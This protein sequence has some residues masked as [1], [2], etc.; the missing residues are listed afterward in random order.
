MD[1]CKKTLF[2]S[3]A[4]L[5]SVICGC[6]DS[7]KEIPPIEPKAVLIHPVV[8][9]S[10]S[11][12][13]NK[14]KEKEGLEEE[15]SLKI[16]VIGP[17]TGEE[18]VWGLSVVEGVL[19]A[20]GRFNRQGGVDGREIEVLHY[21]TGGSNGAHLTE[22]AV[23]DLVRQKA[24]A[25]ISAPTGWSTFA[26]TRIVNET[27]TIFISV[28]TRRRIG[29][30]GPY[31]FRS[32][33]ADELATDNLIKYAT[34]V[35]NYTDF[36][37]VTSSQ[38]DYS[39]D[40]SALFKR[41]IF[42]HR[43]TLS[44]DADTYDTYTGKQNLGG[45]MDALKAQADTLHAVIFTG[46]DSGGVLFAQ[47]MR[48]VGLDQPILGGEDLFTKGYLAGGEAVVGSLLYATFSPHRKS[49]KVA[50]FKQ[51][52]GKDNPD[53]FAALAY[54]TF[55]LIAQAIQTAG[56]TRTSKVRDAIVDTKDFEGATGKMSFTPKGTPVKDSFIYRVAKDRDGE[57]FVLL[58]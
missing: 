34:E 15:R 37:M 57:K 25:I 8:T 33:L 22:R 16:G 50:E 3:A 56:S 43:G 38:Y 53:R 29:R 21:D 2:V 19:A 10:T 58:Q 40:L 24:I 35:L 7:E 1:L 31:V 39:L 23:M 5:F 13:G 36:A 55:M 17:E 49:P 14:K 42:K 47:E 44:V 51:D 12:K 11:T 27:Q 46:G 26:P 45:V 20:A 41:A 4:L 32:S 52:Y 6:S 9:P 54:D 48:G 30:S 18:A 28:G